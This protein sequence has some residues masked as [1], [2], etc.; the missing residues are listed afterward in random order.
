MDYPHQ[1]ISHY[2]DKYER[3]H[4]RRTRTES[5]VSHT[6]ELAQALVKIRRVLQVA[7]VSSSIPD[8]CKAAENLLTDTLPGF[9]WTAPE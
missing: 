4:R 3:E 9:D 1:D 2:R 8:A 7:A 5:I 6:H